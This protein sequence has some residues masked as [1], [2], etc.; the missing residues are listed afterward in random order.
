MRITSLALICAL[1]PFTAIAKPK[2]AKNVVLLVADAGGVAT[3]NAASI[4]GYNAPQKLFIQSW[5]HV[6]LSDTTPVGRWVSDSAAGMTAL[7]TGTKTGNGVISQGPDAV[8]GKTDGTIL[9][10]ILEYAE[11]R[12]LSTGVLSNVTITDAT[13]GACYAHANDRRMWGEIFL[14]L[15]EPRFG[16]GVDVLAGPGRKAIFERVK[17]LGKDVDAVSKEKGRPVYASLADVDPEAKR[18]LVVLDGD[19]DLNDAAKRA[20][21]ML[22]QNKK[23]FFL[24]IESDAHVNNPEVGLGRLVNFD[25]L[26]REISMMVNPKETLFLFTADHSFDIRITG[27]GG[28]ELPLLSGIEEWRKS[29]GGKPP[30][31][32]PGIRIENSH[33]A[34]EVPVMATGPSAELVRGY[35]PNTNIFS[36]MMQAFG[37][38]PAR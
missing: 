13:P 35:M 7:V 27:N 17:Q 21:R 30:I 20:V 4:Y 28:P 29:G 24:M 38:Q 33:T 5:P 25:K 15:F 6:G 2:R 18:A 10:T 16:D 8:R 34:E 32:L 31:R 36:I 9:K 3:V 23:G 12:G 37:W 11:E 14:Q 19:I 26:I 22:S 1:L